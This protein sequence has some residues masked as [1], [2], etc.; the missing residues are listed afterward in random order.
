MIK[1][2]IASKRTSEIIKKIRS[3]GILNKFRKGVTI[4]KIKPSKL[5]IKNLG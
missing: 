1:Y 3:F 2:K 5:L 4:I